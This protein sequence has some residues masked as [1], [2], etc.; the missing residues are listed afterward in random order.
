MG[1][2]DGLIKKGILHDCKNP[3]IGGIEQEGVIINRADIDFSAVVFDSL[4][5]N[6]ISEL[7]LRTDAKAYKV[8]IPTSKPF[9]GTATTMEKGTNR[10][11][12]TH[13]VGMVILDNSPDVCDSIIDSLA[14]GKF[15]VI[16][17]NKYKNTNKKENAGDSAFQI[18]GY[19][20]GME[21]STQR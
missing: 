5:D 9:S 12:F 3:V 15:V 16:L 21:A 6:V 2:C 19:Y 4:R 13:N 11:S 7:V 1:F 14:S 17:E 8:V 18:Y 20:Q 10:N